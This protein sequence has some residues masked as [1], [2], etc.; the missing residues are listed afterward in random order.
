MSNNTCVMCGR[1]FKEARVV[2]EING[3]K[4]FFDKQECAVIM[5]KLNSVYGNDFCASVQD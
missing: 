5:R 4:Y 1:T 2:E 3:S